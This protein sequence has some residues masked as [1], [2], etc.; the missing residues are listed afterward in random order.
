[1]KRIFAAIK[2]E[3]NENLLRVYDELKDD[4]RYEKIK[5][6]EPQN[7]HITLKFFGETSDEKI[8]DICEVFDVIAQRHPA[9]TLQMQNV[10]IFG[11]SYNPRVVWFGMKES[12]EIEKL[13][14]DVLKSVEEVGFP[15]DRQNFRPHL[16]VGRIK[17]IQ[18]KRYFQQVIN[19]FK[20]TFLQT[21]PVNSFLLIESKLRP[22]GSV[23]N[24]V[25]VFP[26]CDFNNK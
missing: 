20:N 15:R 22:Q 25:E 26:L 7:I 24:I 11:S 9:F 5:W 18:D 21:I 17:V 12:S 19:K 6:V 3:P 16:T 23:Y 14:N 8:D 13:A 2:V 1:M 4:L 10:G